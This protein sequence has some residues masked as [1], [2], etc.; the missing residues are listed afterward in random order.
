MKALVFDGKL[1]LERSYPEPGIRPGW[2]KIRINSAGICRT[3]LELT[4]GYMGFK[5]ALGHEFAGTVE[6]CGDKEWVGRRVVGE[7][8][9]ACRECEWC[10]VDMG[11]HCPDR[12]VLGIMNHDGCMAE[13]C[14]LPTANLC[15]VPDNLPDD[16]AVFTEPVSAACEILEQVDVGKKDRCIVLGDGKLGILCAW[17][18]CTVSNDVT[19]VGRHE[20]KLERARWGGLN[21]SPSS[22]KQ[23]DAS[24]DIVVEAT[25]SENGL[26]QALR[27]CRPRGVVVLKSTVA[28]GGELNLAPAVINEITL[29]GSRCG[30]FKDGLEM[31]TKRDLPLNRLIDARYPLDEAEAAFEHA[32]RRGVLKILLEP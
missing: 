8:N 23:P 27:L 19:L 17:A 2:A 14:A 31:I 22:E 25:G 16:R 10:A 5:G 32:G 18:L 26:A 3:D 28:A 11:R 24:A 20:S 15:T 4:K 21:T 6:D 29:V 9:A 1:H 7:I 12:T 13:Y 30:R